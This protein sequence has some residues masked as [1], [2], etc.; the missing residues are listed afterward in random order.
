MVGRI[1]R[2]VATETDRKYVIMEVFNVLESRDQRYGM[3][4]VLASPDHGYEV[5]PP[6]VSQN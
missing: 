1:F 6:S 2:I 5:V 4:A 3:P